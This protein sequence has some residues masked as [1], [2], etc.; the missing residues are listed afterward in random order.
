MKYK[1]GNGVAEKSFV[2]IGEDNRRRLDELEARVAMLEEVLNNTGKGCLLVSSETA[3][4]L[5]TNCVIQ[6]DIPET[7]KQE[8]IDALRKMQ[9]ELYRLSWDRLSWEVE[10]NGD[11]TDDKT[12]G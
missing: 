2:S 4:Y 5:A 1:E 9:E 10:T 12:F 3:I 8:V 7:T 11:N 6:S